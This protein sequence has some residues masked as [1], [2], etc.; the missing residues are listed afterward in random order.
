[1]FGLAVTAANANMPKP[2]AIPVLLYRANIVPLPPS[3]HPPDTTRPF[4]GQH[5]AFERLGQRQIAPNTGKRRS[6]LAVD[7]TET[8]FRGAEGRSRLL[9]KEHGRAVTPAVGQR[10]NPQPRSPCL[11][12]ECGG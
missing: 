8:A 1:L 9:A 10:A 4:R 11:A 6:K 3:Q 7:G 5:R 12:V 2:R